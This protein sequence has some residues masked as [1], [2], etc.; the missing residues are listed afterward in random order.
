MVVGVVVTIISTEMGCYTSCFCGSSG[1]QN[2]TTAVATVA[3]I[4]L[5]VESLI[6]IKL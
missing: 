4:K 5:L 3:V 1:F 2:N 6:F